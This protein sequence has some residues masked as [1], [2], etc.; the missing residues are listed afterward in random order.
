MKHNRER[1]AWTVLLVSF[2]IFLALLIGIPIGIY[3]F[4]QHATVPSRMVL[5]T[6]Q[7]IT[8]VEP[9]G[10]AARLVQVGEEPMEID[11]GTTISSNANTDVL[12]TI[13]S[14][15]GEHTLGTVQIYPNT[16]LTIGKASSPRFSLSNASH[17]I[18]IRVVTGRVRL[19]LASQTERATD[20][21]GIT[22]HAQFLLWETGSYSLDVNSI[23]SQITV[24]EGKATIYINR[25]KQ[26]SLVEAQRGVAATDG[27]LTGPLRPERDLVTNGHFRQP[28]EVG[29]R[30]RTDSV[31]PNQSAGTAEITTEGGQE[32]VRLYRAGSNHAETGIYQPLNT[33]LIDYRSLQVHL[34]GRLDMQ[35]LGVCGTLGSECPLMLRLRYRD[36]SGNEKDWVQGFYYWVDP[37]VP[38]EQQPTLCILCPSPRQEHEQQSQG[39][40]F[41]YDS[42]N[43]ME[44]L[45][46]DGQPPASLVEIAIYSSGHSYDVQ[47]NEV[48]LLVSE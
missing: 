19:G 44:I 13:S 22:D 33:S 21:R 45:S 5:Q 38:V 6:V 4:I 39:V 15:D 8:Q 24:R 34:S 3:Q 26:L 37:A 46:Q 17:Q 40:Q 18:E 32:A 23:N 1:L 20:I 48:E 35:S 41:F 28:L 14:T 2:S 43:L 16:E 7:G 10:E 29:W 31:D 42:L 25:D 11:A 9:P 36:Q 12:L 30:I 47:V 27:S